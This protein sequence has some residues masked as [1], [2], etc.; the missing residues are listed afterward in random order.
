MQNSKKNSTK[1][2]IKDM[3][4]LML[5]IF[6]TLWDYKISNNMRKYILGSVLLN[7]LFSEGLQN[8]YQYL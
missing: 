4:K 2:A 3:Q 5:N 8:P 6:K 7:H 1:Y